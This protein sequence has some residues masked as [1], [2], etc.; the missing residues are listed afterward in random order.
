MSGV[1]LIYGGGGCYW[2]PVNRK[3][4]HVAFTQPVASAL[5]AVEREARRCAAIQVGEELVGGFV[6]LSTPLSDALMRLDAA[7]AQ[8]TPT[9][10]PPAHYQID[11]STPGW[12]TR[13]VDAVA[14][15]HGW[16][17]AEAQGRIADG[18]AG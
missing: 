4:T 15:E 3:P 13:Y 5:V 10:H 11:T 9:I 2:E 12:N 1:E 18:G 14:K 16:T 7:R 17:R 8:Q 6:V